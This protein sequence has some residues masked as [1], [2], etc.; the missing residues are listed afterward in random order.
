MWPAVGGQVAFKVLD[1][2][3]S[4][5]VFATSYKL[6]YFPLTSSMAPQSVLWH[7]G[8]TKDDLVLVED[9]YANRSAPK[10][11]S[12]KG[13]PLAMVP[14]LVHDDFVMSWPQSGETFRGRANAVGAMKAQR[15]VP[16]IVGEPRIVGDGNVWVA[17]M[18]LRYGEDIFHYVGILELDGG[19][20][21]R[22]TGYFGAPFPPQ[23]DRA[24]FADR[25]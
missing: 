24:E 19:R 22:G 12:G 25:P 21:R 20:I 3:P 7:L 14:I 8:G 16:E 5:A 15:V 13:H 6:Y 18:P 10:P 11:L 23:D 17:M 2:L 4:K 9:F 1:H